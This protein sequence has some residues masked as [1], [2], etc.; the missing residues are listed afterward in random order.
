M[1]HTWYGAMAS[2]ILALAAGAA[3]AQSVT[4]PGVTSEADGLFATF[5][6]DH[7]TTSLGP[8][9][10]LLGSPPPGSSET[11]MLGV[12]DQTI[13]LPPLVPGIVYP[14][15]AQFTA[16]AYG[17]RSHIAAVG[18]STG[19]VTTTASAQ[20]AGSDL[21]ITADDGISP[22]V[23]TVPFLEVAAT[24]VA[25][26][27]SL[28]KGALQPGKVAGSASFTALSIAGSLL[29]GHAITVTG[30]EPP[31]TL[32][33]QSPTVTIIADQQTVV[34][35]ITCDPQCHYIASTIAVHAL[36]IVL[37]NAPILGRPVSGEIVLGE[38]AAR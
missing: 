22:V 38:A 12:F 32:L 19:S 30:A 2:G 33:Y 5:T 24:G 3:L 21:R 11:R 27:A 1:K 15:V 14:V 28:T 23:A 10:E 25:A 13:A 34:G 6:A 36:D 26:S 20:V 8:V 9:D 29:G 37:D 18:T 4:P 31:D 16:Q 7:M 17:L 35:L